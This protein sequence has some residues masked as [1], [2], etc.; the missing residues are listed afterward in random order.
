MTDGVG[1][2]DLYYT[3]HSYY[4]VGSE[5]IVKSIRNRWK[6]DLFPGGML[7]I[8]DHLS[9]ISLWRYGPFFSQWAL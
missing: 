3:H 1:C 2:T 7:I 6:D 4:V 8:V 9:V 5:S